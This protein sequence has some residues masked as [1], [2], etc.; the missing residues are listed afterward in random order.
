MP[1]LLQ[2][3]DNGCYD[4]RFF[5]DYWAKLYF[6]FSINYLQETN[7][8]HDFIFEISYREVLLIYPKAMHNHRYQRFLSGQEERVL[9]FLLDQDDLII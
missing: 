3:D 2:R 8:L 7:V 6:R 5:L 4:Y 9:A 1:K